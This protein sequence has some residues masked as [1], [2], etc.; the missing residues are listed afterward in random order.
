MSRKVLLIGLDCADPRLVFEAWRSD[1]PQL[2]RLMTQG[3]FGR[4]RSCDPPITVPA[5]SSMMTSLDPGQLGFYGFRNRADYTYDKMGIATSRAVPHTTV[6]DV[7]GAAGKSSVLLGV[8]QTYPPRP[9]QG[10][11]VTCFLTPSVESQYTYPPELKQTIATLIEDEYIFDVADFRSDDKQR[12]LDAIYA[13]T[14]Q[15]CRVFRHLLQTNSWEYG[16]VVLMGTDR[17]QHGFWQYCFADHPL[18][19][20]DN[21]LEQVIHD[22]Y[23]YVDQEIGRILE[24]VDDDTLVLVVSDHGA[25]GMDGGICINEW[26]MREGYLVLHEQPEGI[27]P[28]EKAQVDWSR[29]SVWAA[30]GYYARVYVNIAGREPQGIVPA[31]EA[32]HL[33]DEIAAKL[34]A[35]GD[36]HGNPIGTWS[37]KPVDIYQ[38]VRNVAPDLLVYFG[39]LAW[40]SLGTIGH[41][42]IHKR[43]NDTGPD[44]ANH[45][46]HGILIAY[47]PRNPQGGQRLADSSLLDIAPSVLSELGVEPLAAMRGSRIN[48]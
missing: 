25:R 31:D 14:Q 22:Y 10:Q 47:D 17:I 34:A 3:S 43:E 29:T 16:M 1:L 4:L 44:G 28:L 2:N 26:L 33:V 32:D 40:R 6:W 12:I 46:W 37:V 20:P 13:M 19:T 30:G 42:V 11:M 23:V 38:E 41:G 7:L 35:L 36:E 5:W 27:V 8:P 39:D 18:Y 48:W 24:C 45:D 21:G 15:Q 9:I